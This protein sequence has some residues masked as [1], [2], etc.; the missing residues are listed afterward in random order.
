MRLYDLNHCCRTFCYLQMKASV[1]FFQTLPF[2]GSPAQQIFPFLP[3]QGL[4]LHT[5]SSYFVPSHHPSSFYPELTKLTC[6]LAPLAFS[7]LATS[8]LII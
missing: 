1:L 4:S 8:P 2:V 3:V 5:Y 6:T 7:L